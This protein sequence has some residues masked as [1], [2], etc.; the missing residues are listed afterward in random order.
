MDIAAIWPHALCPLRLLPASGGIGSTDIGLKDDACP[1]AARPVVAPPVGGHDLVKVLA[2]ILKRQAVPEAAPDGFLQVA[3]KIVLHGSGHHER[4]AV[5][6]VHEV[7]I[8]PGGDAH[9]GLEKV[10]GF[11]TRR[12]FELSFP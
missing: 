1:P 2:E 7:G 8:G 5:R 4:P 12:A 6:L 10:D 11:P 9:L 3:Q